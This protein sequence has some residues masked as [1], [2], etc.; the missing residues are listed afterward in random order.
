MNDKLIKVLFCLS[1]S[2]S[3]RIVGFARAEVVSRLRRR[4]VK[5]SNTRENETE[6]KKI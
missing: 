6:K 3:L 5:R 1:R 4:A 2:I